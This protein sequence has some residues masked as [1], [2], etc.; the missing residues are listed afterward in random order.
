MLSRRVIQ[1]ATVLAVLTTVASAAA[2]K[3]LVPADKG[4]SPAELVALRQR[5]E[6]RIYRGEALYT[7]G[8]PCGGIGAGQLYVRGDGTLACWQ[9]DGL[10]CFTGYGAE[11]YRTYRPD[12]VI[13]QGFAIRTTDADGEQVVATLDQSAYDAIEFIGEYPRALIRYRA[14]DKTVPPVDVDLEV[15]SPFCP[16][17][18]ADSGWPATV[19]RFSVTNPTEQNLK[20][21]LGGWLENFTCWNHGSTA[22]LLRQNRRHVQG[23]FN[24]LIMETI[25]R[26]FPRLREP[27]THVIADFESGDYEGWTVTGDAF[28]TTPVEGTLP[29]QQEVHAYSGKRLVNSYLGGDRTV[30]KLTSDPFDIDLPFMTLR[31]GGGLHPGQTCV[32]LVVNGKVVRTATGRN[33]EWLDLI[34]WDL[35]PLLGKRGHLEIVDQHQGAWGHIN[36]DDIALSNTLPKT[37]TALDKSAIDYGS[38]ALALLDS[39]DVTPLWPGREK[40]LSSLKQ[41]RRMRSGIVHRS[42]HEPCVGTLRKDFKLAPGATREV[43][44]VIAWHFPNL[45]GAPNRHYT[46]RAYDALNVAQKLSERLAELR[47]KTLLFCEN[48]Y[49]R[50]TMPWWLNER[51]MMPVSTLA[52]E[53][54]Q[55]RRDGRFWA[56]EGVGCCPGTCTHVWNYAQ[57]HAYLFPELA[58]SVR[59]RQDFGEALDETTGLVGFRGDDRFA[60]DGQAGTIL[61]SYREHRNSGDLQFLQRNWTKIK[62][63]LEHLISHDPDENGIIE[64]GRQ[65]TTYDIDLA[66]PN[67]F[68][69]ALYIAALRAGAVMAMAMDETETA[70][71]YQAIADRGG[72]WTAEHLFN[73]EYYEQQ[74]SA[75]DKRPWQYGSGCLS[76]QL[77]GQNWAHQLG[78][79]ELYPRDQIRSALRAVYQHNWA[80]DVGPYNAQHPPER[81][82]ARAGEPGLLNCT[83][84]RGGRPDEPVRYR[85]EVWT[86]IEYQVA[87][88]LAWEGLVDEA[89][90]IVRG[91]DQRYDGVKHNP[92]NEVECGDHYARALA[93]WGVRHAL[94]GFTFDGPAGTLSFAPRLQPDDF[95]AFFCAGEGWGTLAQERGPNVQVNCVLVAHGKLRLRKL[96]L[97][98]PEGV[99]VRRVDVRHV[100][101]ADSTI[102]ETELEASY[103]M[104]DDR[105]VIEL[106]NAVALVADEK[107]LVTLN[108]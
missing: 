96:E 5:G 28:G 11:C 44:I 55:W 49:R 34:A 8:M 14:A 68:V 20:V 17:E 50:S 26:D 24:A 72:A 85:N 38:L 42:M 54:V 95:E 40:F 99:R 41:P 67:T 103:V 77:F 19:L 60:A 106:P 104:K 94:M 6:Q 33:N 36:V 65:H 46:T 87:A 80:P 61:K 53:T 4:V 71:R 59:E 76:D 82:F 100:R 81:W 102:D 3:H 84:P 62:L 12:S 1:I 22:T 75:G 66:G 93:C 69:G 78:L 30:G 73:G 89:L 31:V 10:S 18:A 13:E 108:W 101:A 48:Y 27:T 37:L 56:W 98:P 105:C 70:A 39:G 74:I 90:Q 52:T 88:G 57:A 47:A 64:H 29:N 9:V 35:R 23:K 92:W 16:L 43:T 21:A 7:I 58:R 63:A 51:L 15:F 83:W 45:L 79:G 32:N 97:T 86:G 25:E 2:D 107:L 91:I